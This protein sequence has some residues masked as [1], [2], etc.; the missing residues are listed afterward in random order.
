MV[1]LQVRLFVLFALGTIWSCEEVVGQLLGAVAVSEPMNAF[2]CPKVVKIRFNKLK[3]RGPDSDVVYQRTTITEQR[4]Q[5]AAN[6]TVDLPSTN[7]VVCAQAAAAEGLDA[8]VFDGSCTGFQLGSPLF[9]CATGDITIFVRSE[10]FA[11][12]LWIINLERSGLPYKMV[13][14]Y[15]SFSFVQYMM[16]SFIDPEPSNLFYREGSFEDRI[17]DESFITRENGDTFIAHVTA[18][19]YRSCLTARNNSVTILVH[20]FIPQ[21]NIGIGYF[22]N[23]CGNT[24]RIPRKSQAFATIV[25]FHEG[26][27]CIDNPSEV[28]DECTV[29][30]DTDEPNI[31]IVCE[32]SDPKLADGCPGFNMTVTGSSLQ[33]NQ[34]ETINSCTNTGDT[35]ST[36]HHCIT[37]RPGITASP[38]DEASLHH[39]QTKH[40][41]I[42]TRPSI[43][44][45]PPD[46]VS[47]HHHQ[48]KYHCITI[49]TSITA[50]LSDQ[51][52]LHHYQIKHH[53]IMIRSN[54]TASP[55]D[56]ASLHHHHTKHH[57]ITA[58]SSDQASLHHH[59][60]KY[61]CIIRSSI[62]ASR[63]D[64][65][66][67][68]HQIKHHCITI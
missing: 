7:I 17:N 52:S 8:F 1:T 32:F 30:F 21:M 16:S 31:N 63:S 47:L 61:H 59:M 45:S 20:R 48:T 62:T 43:T 66:S 35:I 49:R 34:T 41:C 26:L 4:L 33:S 29:T 9:K 57:C 38:S 44:G 19:D 28:H 14:G 53:C 51:T 25:Y 36:K 42:T 10:K 50:S 18:V 68:H 56:Q 15:G 23:E 54:I 39:H 40:H 2:G 5:Y 11:N 67:L 22:S 12:E 27:G 24:I 64:Q 37:T 65:A 13:E 3:A 58:S 6:A 55:S 46:Q 60:I